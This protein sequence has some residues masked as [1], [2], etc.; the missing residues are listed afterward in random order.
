M[1]G[2]SHKNARRSFDDTRLD[3]TMAA[4]SSFNGIAEAG[5]PD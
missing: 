2:R 3:H 5:E 1:E 4:F